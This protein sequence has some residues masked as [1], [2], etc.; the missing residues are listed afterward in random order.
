MISSKNV[1]GLA[2][3]SVEA[4]LVDEESPKK[5]P[6]KKPKKRVRDAQKEP[7]K[8]GRK[9]VDPLKK[10][11]GQSVSLPFE[12]WAELG[13]LAD[14]ADLRLSNYVHRVMD[15]HLRNGGVLR[16]ATDSEKISHLEDLQKQLK[17]VI[18]S[19]K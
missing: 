6:E 13:R 15:H 1:E 10:K 3:A 17:E 12:M 5:T 18:Q 7:S 8:R 19:L 4:A 11:I 16:K 14:E 9:K 2:E